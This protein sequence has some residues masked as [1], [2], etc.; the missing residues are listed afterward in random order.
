MSE[1][2]LAVPALPVTLRLAEYLAVAVV[3]SLP[4]S[5]SATSILV[6]LWLL[7]VVPMLEIAELRRVVLTPAGGLPLLVVALAVLGMLWADV[8]WAERYDG[9]ATFAKLAVIPV[10]MTQFRRV[11]DPSPVLVGFLLSCGALLLLSWAFVIGGPVDPSYFWTQKQHGIPV[12]DYISQSA[13]FTIAV[14]ALID[15]ALTE[16]RAGRMARAGAFI[17]AASLFLA[18]MLYVETSRTTL[19]VAP[20]LLL[21]F[22]LVRLDWKQSIAVVAVGVIVAA[23]AYG[24][25]PY[26]RERAGDI[27]VFQKA[28]GKE[29]SSGDRLAFWTMSLHAIEAA[30]V[31]GSG[32]GSIREVFE[33]QGSHSA[34]NPHNQFFAVAI[35]LG[36]IGLAVLVAMWAAHWLLFLRAPSSWLGLI[37]VTQNVVSSLFNSHLSD[38]THGWIYVF[39]VGIAAGVAMR[40]TSLPRSTAEA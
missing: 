34:L 7:A 23:V 17:A 40:P 30:P 4:W 35:Q 9:V 20:V 16:W 24:S 22:G 2:T 5:T 32:T 14:F 1:K 33:R 21:L 18:N 12:K 39:G 8:P 29:T 28:N 15:L 26:L 6:V 38:F 36:I 27:F 11:E 10:L 13:I 25:S 3:V 37:V 31:L 19:V